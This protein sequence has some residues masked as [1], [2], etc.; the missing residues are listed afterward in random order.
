MVV[1]ELRHRLRTGLSTLCH[2][3]VFAD[4]LKARVPHQELM[5][6]CELLVP[7]NTPH[8]VLKDQWMFMTGDTWHSKI[9]LA[10]TDVEYYEALK[11]AVWCVHEVMVEDLFTF[12]ASATESIIAN[13]AFR[14]FENETY[15]T[16]PVI[17]MTVDKIIESYNNGFLAEYM[18]NQSYGDDIDDKI[19]EDT[20]LIDRISEMVYSVHEIMLFDVGLG[21]LIAET[22]REELNIRSSAFGLRKQA[23]LT[24][25][26]EGLITADPMGKHVRFEGDVAK[27]VLLSLI[28]HYDIGPFSWMPELSLYINDYQYNCYSLPTT[29]T[30]VETVR[31]VCVPDELLEGLEIKPLSHFIEE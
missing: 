1:S 2:S 27:S 7:K 10:Y 28:D 21:A 23:D 14:N 12:I 5:T 25:Y 17:R 9:V 13:N 26:T 31:S 20:D 18:G 30:L 4:V 6:Y 15:R 19:L 8:L 24:L 22:V 11:A 16:S 29:E 3:V